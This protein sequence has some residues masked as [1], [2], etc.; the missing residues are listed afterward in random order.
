MRPI[1]YASLVVL[2]ATSLLFA[3]SKAERR[4]A[5]C[6]TVLEEIL[7]IPDGIPAELLDKAECVVVFP[8][9]KKFAI[10]IGGSYGAGRISIRT[11]ADARPT[12]MTSGV[13]TMSSG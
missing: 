9:V 5:N 13:I 10:A 1:L 7:N 8:S 2:L 12:S 6:A 11:G 4:L 3:A